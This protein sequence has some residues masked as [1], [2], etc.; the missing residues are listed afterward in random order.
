MTSTHLPVNQPRDV[1]A[2]GSLYLERFVGELWVL[3]RRVGQVGVEVFLE[4][5]QARP[6]GLPGAAHVPVSE[7]RPLHAS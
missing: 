1:L 3:L 7:R 6:Q 5:R 4:A 2:I